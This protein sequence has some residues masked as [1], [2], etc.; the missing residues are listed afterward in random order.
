MKTLQPTL[1][2][3][4]VALALIGCAPKDKEL[5]DKADSLE[6]S[7]QELN[8]KVDELAAKT[9]ELSAQNE[10]LKNELEKENSSLQQRLSY[11]ERKDP[12]LAF[13]RQIDQ[14]KALYPDALSTPTGLHYIVTQEGKGEETPKS[15]ALVV[16]HYH[17]TL[18]DGK[19]FDSS[20]DR[21]QPFSFQVGVGRVIRGWDEAFLSMKKG[22]KRKLI[23]PSK[24]G[25]GEQG[26][27]PV[28]PAN[29]ILVFD[30]ELI[31][32]K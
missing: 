12:V 19:K 7:T 18:I 14:I 25:Y 22:E 15:G 13:D 6:N 20:I 30:V 24:L 29:A 23:I 11:L 5:H 3:S 10:A 4:I 31:N 32:F 2:A 26:A 28:I 1:A 17:G 8:Q 16:A 27:P 21:Q 9:H